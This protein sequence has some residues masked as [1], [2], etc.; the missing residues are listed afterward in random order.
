[1][2]TL[3]DELNLNSNTDTINFIKKS[4]WV[5]V[6]QDLPE[7]LTSISYTFEK[8]NYKNYISYKNFIKKYSHI[9]NTD[10]FS[11]LK[12]EN[13]WKNSLKEIHR[14]FNFLKWRFN[15][16]K[17]WL[18]KNWFDVEDILEAVLKRLTEQVIEA[19]ESER[20]LKN[21]NVVWLSKFSKN[22]YLFTKIPYYAFAS[23]NVS[24]DV[25]KI[26]DKKGKEHSLRDIDDLL[27]SR[28]DEWGLFLPNSMWVSVSLSTTD[29][30]WNVVFIAQE[31]NNATTLSQNK[32]KY[33]ASASWAV[34]FSLFLWWETLDL[35]HWAI[36]WEVVE[37][38]WVDSLKSQLTQ[39]EIS[40]QVSLSTN[41]ILSWN[42]E[43]E[44]ICILWNLL[45][46]EWLEILKR[47]LWLNANLLPV[48]LVMEEKRRN[49]E[50]VFLWRIWDTLE[51]IKKSW[52]TAKSK[53]ESLSI[54]W[55]TFSE[56]LTELENRKNWWEKSIDD[57]FF[58]SLLWYFLKTSK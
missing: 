53:S 18:N 42:P 35:L 11:N 19:W 24:L 13:V 22:E 10:D 28:N 12:E 16:A 36:Q 15:K 40:S 3:S 58:M 54:K 2:K 1:M 44:K 14:T 25:V 26:K 43:Y 8:D 32:A 49:P 45:M 20:K 31:R 55:I 21:W 29:K 27:D 30:D 47:E 38:L 33:I 37:E 23:T 48:A 41:W 46:S 57:H 9:I 5:E 52:E 34:D 56:I 7:D 39:S 17:E 4:A 51:Q 6:L 50:F